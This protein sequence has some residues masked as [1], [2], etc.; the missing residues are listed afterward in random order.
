MPCPCSAM[1]CPCRAMACPQHLLERDLGLLRAVFQW[2]DLVHRPLRLDGAGPSWLPINALDLAS[3]AIEISLAP[4]PPLHS[5]PPPPCASPPAG[6]VALQRARADVSSA[7]GAGVMEDERR[8]GEWGTT[9]GYRWVQGM[10]TG[11]GC[12]G[13]VLTVHRERERVSQ[14]VKRAVKRLRQSV[15]AL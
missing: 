15:R 3:H 6:R 8:T 14:S 13:W 1:P 10:D 9:D 7:E 12:R 5:L 4:C 2:G 11:D